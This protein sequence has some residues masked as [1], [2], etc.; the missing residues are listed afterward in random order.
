MQPASLLRL[1]PWKARF[2]TTFHGAHKKGAQAAHACRVR[3]YRVCTLRRRGGSIK[4]FVLRVTYRC[5][6]V[7]NASRAEKNK[8]HFSFFYRRSISGRAM[9][10]GKAKHRFWDRAP[11]SAQRAVGDRDRRTGV[12]RLSTRSGGLWG[13]LRGC[14]GGDPEPLPR[15][16]KGLFPFVKGISCT[17]S[18][19]NSSAPIRSPF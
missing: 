8:T 3:Q 19:A 5:R 17:R 1:I 15:P 13:F 6:A 7:G 18:L 10:I 2:A 11:P 9:P 16:L 12:R 4:R 14:K